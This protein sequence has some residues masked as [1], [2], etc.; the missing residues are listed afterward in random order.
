MKQQQLIG[1][2]LLSGFLLGITGCGQVKSKRSSQ[3]SSSHSSQQRAAAITSASLT[4]TGVSPTVSAPLR[5]PRR[6]GSLR[7]PPSPVTPA[8]AVAS[9][10]SSSTTPKKPWRWPNRSTGMITATTSGSS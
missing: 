5:P 2:L 3:A 6:R 8:K 1:A 9:P 4:S 10:G 7:P